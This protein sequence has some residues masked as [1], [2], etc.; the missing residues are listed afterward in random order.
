MRICRAYPNKPQPIVFDYI[1]SHY[2]SYYQFYNKKENCRL[3]ALK[4]C[5]KIHSSIKDFTM[6][7]S[8]LLKVHHMDEVVWK[9][10]YPK[11]VIDVNK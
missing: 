1:Y 6:A 9:E 8:H 5:T 4:D 11:Y 3:N 2:M 10:V 7:M